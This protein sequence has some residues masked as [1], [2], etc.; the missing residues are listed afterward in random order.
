MTTDSLAALVPTAR[1]SPVLPAGLVIG[2]V[3][4]VSPR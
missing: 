3:A 4:L 2:T 1:D